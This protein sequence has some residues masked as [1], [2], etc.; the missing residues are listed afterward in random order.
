[1]ILL[2]AIVLEYTSIKKKLE[3]RDNDSEFLQDS[4]QLMDI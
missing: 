3:V 2:V 1:M 4:A